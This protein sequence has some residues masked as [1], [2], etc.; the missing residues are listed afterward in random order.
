MDI[1]SLL[2]LLIGLSVLILLVMVWLGARLQTLENRRAK[3]KHDSPL[4]KDQLAKLHEEASRQYE[5]SM[6]RELKRFESELTKT[7]DDL[8]AKLKQQVGDPDAQLASTI[9]GL[10][11]TTTTGYTAA[12]D[13]SVVQLKTRLATIDQMIA[14]HAEQADQAVQAL[15]DERKAAAL[16]RVDAALGELFADYMA[17]VASGLDLSDQQTLILQQLESIKPQLLEDIKRA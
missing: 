11:Q 8:L 5:A 9:N 13:Q 12:L 7:S 14:T 4:T 15:V 6:V 17:T 10:M 16:S 3:V 2:L 1:V